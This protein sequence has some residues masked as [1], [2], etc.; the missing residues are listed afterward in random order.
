MAGDPQIKR[1]IWLAAH[2]VYFLNMFEGLK[3]FCV[4]V[5]LVVLA[6]PL[7]MPTKKA[8]RRGE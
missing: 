5:A 8:E 3:C 7:P 6:E 2:K 4:F 1:K